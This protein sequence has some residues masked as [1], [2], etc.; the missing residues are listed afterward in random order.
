MEY[1]LSV[2]SNMRLFMFDTTPTEYSDILFS[3]RPSYLF[4]ADPLCNSSTLTQVNT[5]NARSS[6][7]RKACMLP[8][9][10]F[11]LSVKA[12]MSFQCGRGTH[13][14]SFDQTGSHGPRH[15]RS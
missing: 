6:R 2:V 12:L 10:R 13:L 8:W 14:G 11:S 1:D 7:L 4:S 15:K 5:W 9:G 3:A